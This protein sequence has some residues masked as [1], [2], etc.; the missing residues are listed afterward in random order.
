MSTFADFLFA[1]WPVLAVI[2][3]C[4]VLASFVSVFL[5]KSKKAGPA[6][7]GATLQRPTSP[8]AAIDPVAE[9]DEKAPPEPAGY[10]Q[11]PQT[12]PQQRREAFKEAMLIADSVSDLADT[13]DRFTMQFK[14]PPA[15]T[16]LTSAFL[17]LICDDS[18]SILIEPPVFIGGVDAKSA[19]HIA[20]LIDLVNRFR[21]EANWL[22][23]VG[24]RSEIEPEWSTV[25]RDRVQS[26]ALKSAALCEELVHL[27][28][29]LHA[30]FPKAG[31]EN[32]P[33]G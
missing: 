21:F 12:S 24:S 31:D 11:K 8:K 3:A 22:L 17:G 15:S 14:A 16:E 25:L 30:T 7:G 26:I 23:E 1:N 13:F 20:I 18:R 29:T 6:D 9:A 10:P 5:M 4:V 2:V 28:E 33:S 32:S 19:E 27:C